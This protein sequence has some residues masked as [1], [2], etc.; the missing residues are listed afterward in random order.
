MSEELASAAA[1]RNTP[2]FAHGEK[3]WTLDGTTLEVLRCGS[4]RPLLVLHGANTIAHDAPFIGLLAQHCEIIAPSHPGFGNSV[5][6][7][8]FDTVYDLVHLYLDIIDRLPG[9]RV[10]LMGFSFGGWLAAEIAAHCTHK[11]DRLILVDCVGIKIGA[12]DTR[13]ISHFF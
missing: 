3:P 9:E 13:D 5:R 4:G 7:E 12:R 11:L 10:S 1:V 2:E 6:P 8:D